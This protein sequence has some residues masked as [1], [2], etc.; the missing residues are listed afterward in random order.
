MSRVIFF[1]RTGLRD[2]VYFT[3]ESRVHSVPGLTDHGKAD[4]GFSWANRE[5]LRLVD[6]K[7][8]HD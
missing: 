3:A 2:N 7:N 5:I 4:F 8:M 6:T 1:T